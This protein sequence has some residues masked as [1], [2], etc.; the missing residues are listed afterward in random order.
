MLATSS[1]SKLSTTCEFSL[2]KNRCNMVLCEHDSIVCYIVY[3][4][5]LIHWKL[6]KKLP[7]LHSLDAKLCESS[8][9]F[10]VCWKVCL[11]FVGIKNTSACMMPCGR[12]DPLHPNKRNFAWSL[13]M[14][15]ASCQVKTGLECMGTEV[16]IEN[17]VF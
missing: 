8:R 13:P 9:F 12:D 17:Q 2:C 16:L 14:L 4:N 3:M 6:P 10:C 5:Q 15:F 7:L 11:H 1:F